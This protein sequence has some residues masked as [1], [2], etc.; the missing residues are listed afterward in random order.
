MKIQRST[1]L[2]KPQITAQFWDCSC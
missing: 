1:N 2:K